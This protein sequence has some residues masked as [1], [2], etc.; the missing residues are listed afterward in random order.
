MYVQAEST[1]SHWPS[2]VRC[3]SDKARE[4]L[5]T[6][7]IIMLFNRWGSTLRLNAVAWGDIMWW[8]ILTSGMAYH[9]PEI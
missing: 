4:T 8:H 3:Q 6:Q 7:T 1:K 9:W 2:A 5:L